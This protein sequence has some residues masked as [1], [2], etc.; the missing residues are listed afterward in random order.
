LRVIGVID[1]LGGLAVHARG[2]KR[3][4]Y[5]VIGDPL[6]L[7]RTYIDRHGV[8]ELYVA[9]LDAIARHGARSHEQAALPTICSIV[10]TWLD[11]GISTVE[12]ARQAIDMGASCVIVGLETLTSF[13]ALA[14]ICDAIGGHRVAC[15]LDLRNGRLLGIGADEHPSAVAERAVAAGA[16]AI[17]ALDLARVGMRTGLDL[18]LMRALRKAAPTVEL[19]AGGGVRGPEDLA[20]LAAAGCDGAL[21]ATALRDGSLRNHSG[22]TG[23]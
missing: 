15:S 20:A 14:A 17:I 23:L 7:A 22:S 21:A 2:G 19:I 13:D 16:H 8:S 1:L 12:H 6:A 10:P 11:A 4:E 18:E 9:D 5:E 3:E